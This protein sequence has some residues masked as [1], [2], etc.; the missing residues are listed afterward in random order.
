M[1]TLTLFLIQ[2]YFCRHY[3][4]Q[5]NKSVQGCDTPIST[6]IARDTRPESEVG[7]T[8]DKGKLA[9]NVNTFAVCCGF[10]D[11]ET[12]EQ[13]NLTP[14]TQEKSPEEKAV[15]EIG[16]SLEAM[17]TCVSG[18]TDRTTQR[19]PRNKR[20]NKTLCKVVKGKGDEGNWICESDDFVFNVRC[21][22]NSRDFSAFE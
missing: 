11:T 17:K 21:D 15:E 2:T 14:E 16:Y 7:Q 9:D 6:F 18:I 5:S 8:W 12:D 10:E 22:Y 20:R 1:R 13:A 3:Q 4:F 19:K